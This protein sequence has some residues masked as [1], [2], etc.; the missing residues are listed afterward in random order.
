MEFTY[1]II[2]DHFS[3][4]VNYFRRVLQVD[5][6][7]S[8]AQLDSIIWRSF[9]HRNADMWHN[10]FLQKSLNG[11]KRFQPP[12]YL[13]RSKNLLQTELFIHCRLIVFYLPVLLFLSLLSFPH[14]SSVFIYFLDYVLP[15]IECF[16]FS[17]N[18]RLIN[19]VKH[20]TIE[21]SREY[22]SC[23]HNRP[24]RLLWLKRFPHNPRITNL[25]LYSCMVN[26]TLTIKTKKIK[27]IVVNISF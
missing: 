9:Y 19:F 22:L 13:V 2:C 5:L 18:L 7:V 20:I 24:S 26:A 11:A 21:E 25:D 8:V 27:E 23:S 1:T 10:F 4:K 15:V 14:L 17:N 16:V 6:Q 3:V 12:A